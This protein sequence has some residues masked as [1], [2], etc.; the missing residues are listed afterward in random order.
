MKSGMIKTRVT[1]CA[2]CTGI[3]FAGSGCGKADGA[4]GGGSGQKEMG[5]Y[6]E[7]SVSY[8]SEDVCPVSLVQENETL[9]LVGQYGKDMVSND[10]GISFEEAEAVPMAD[11]EEDKAVISV[12]AGVSDG[13]RIF[14]E[15]TEGARVWRLVMADGRV[16]E[17]EGLGSK[18]YPSFYQGDGCF[19]MSKGFEIYR[20]DPE[21]GEMTFLTESASYPLHLAADGEMLYVI[22]MD[23]VLL[24]DL[25]K[26][27]TAAKQD[28]VLSAFFAGKQEELLNDATAVLLCPCGEDIYVLSHSGIF[29]HK[30]YGESME[31][32]V[33]GG[34]CSIGDIGRGFAGMAV[35]EVSGEKGDAGNADAGNVDAENAAAGNADA[36]NVDAGNADTGNVDEKNAETNMD[37]VFTVLYTDGK[38]MR[39]VKD[40]TLPAEPEVSLRIY[41]L[42]ED[43]SIRQ[44]VSA[45]RQKYPE[46][47][48]KYEVG[49]NPDY[50]VTREDALRNLS[51]E[52]AAG[53]GPDILAVDDI[54]FEAYAEKGV[55][56][57]LGFLREGMSDE[58][59][60]EAVI[61]G[62]AT[63]KGLYV[64]PLTFAVPALAG[65]AGAL[66]EAGEI[67]SLWQLADLLEKA[68]D[69]E[70]ET[71]SGQESVIGFLSAEEALRLFAQSSMGAWTTEEGAFDREAVTE[72]LTQ[73]KRIYDIQMKDIPEDVQY[74]EI[75]GTNWGSGENT[76]ARRNASYGLGEALD[77]RIMCFPQQ[78]FCAGYVSGAV[79]DFPMTMGKLDYIGGAYALMPGQN[80]GKCLPATLMAMNSGS[81]HEEECRLFLEYIFSAEFQGTVSLNGTPVNKSAYFQRQQNPKAES[82]AP[83]AAMGYALAD[84]T[85]VML[86]VFWPSGEDFARLDSLT[87]S[88]SGVN[89]CD[90][91]IYEAVIELGQAALTGEAGIEE[92]VDG[93]EEEL[94]LY[95]AE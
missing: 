37:R 73:V 93:I 67:E 45:F 72:F 14:E 2:L 24:Y 46:L 94:E 52:L 8:G 91:R 13:S 77:T 50:G 70:G 69:G 65:D 87:E 28:E 9:R 58:E 1:V 15:Y 57:E 34:A 49:V 32:I 64:M 18:D 75:S 22:Q 76:L 31:C 74:M 12:L 66:T 84:G 92:T 21:T 30:L 5:R 95:L 90:G 7:E 48:I 38:L 3:A 40:E 47:Y 83:Y 11:G 55:L 59:Y 42:Y 78:P 85:T 54:L 25:R 19:Y 89:Y 62:F 86:Q 88:I 68:A 6:V 71:M 56:A 35:W 82:E 26:N 41:S 39:Y 61:D 20:I 23:G 36:E 27:Q 79:E 44:A 60:F 10:G 33:D 51:T 4:S 53:T 43:G 16:I 17:L 63:E 81:K 80:F 29:A